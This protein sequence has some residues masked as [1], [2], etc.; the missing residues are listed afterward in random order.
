MPTALIKP[1]SYLSVRYR[2]PRSG[3][4]EYKVEASRPVNTFVLDEEG[5]REFLG[6]GGDV[7]SYYGGFARRYEHRQELRLPFSGWWYLVIDNPMSESVA[8]HYEVSG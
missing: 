5:L 3:L 6:R 4:I 7:Y 1:K 8:V 2:V